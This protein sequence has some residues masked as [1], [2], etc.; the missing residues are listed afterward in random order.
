M[1]GVQVAPN[2][3]VSGGSQ[4][5]AIVWIAAAA[6]ASFVAASADALPRPPVDSPGPAAQK[7]HGFHSSC[8]QGPY[9]TDFGAR[10]FGWHT[11][12][13]PGYTI[14]CRC[15]RSRFGKRHCQPL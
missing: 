2:E 15:W 3:T 4:M 8:E 14:P 13:A 9:R 6:L 10:R 12:P 5:K 11:N 1:R 7:V